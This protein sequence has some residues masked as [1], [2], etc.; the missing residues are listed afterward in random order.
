MVRR[1]RVVFATLGRLIEV[2]NERE[3]LDLANLSVLVMDE[4]DKMVYK[5][6]QENNKGKKGGAKNAIWRDLESVFTKLP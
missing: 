5:L 3:W 4:A 6:K 1:P 2:V